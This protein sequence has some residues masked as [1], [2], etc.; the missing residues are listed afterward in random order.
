MGK[1]DYGKKIK[2]AGFWQVKEKSV[3]CM[4]TG[5]EVV[6]KKKKEKKKEEGGLKTEMHQI[7]ESGVGFSLK[8]GV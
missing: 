6:F 5:S 1:D 2:N 8:K 4:W 3:A 7:F